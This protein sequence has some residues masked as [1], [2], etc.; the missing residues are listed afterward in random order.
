MRL[1]LLQGG[2]DEGEVAADHL[3]RGAVLESF[4]PMSNTTADGSRRRTSSWRRISTPRVVSPLMPRL[5]TFIARKGGAQTPAPTLRDRVAEEDDG[6]LVLILPARPGRA[7]FAPHL[8]ERVVA[9]DRSCPGQAVVRRGNGKVVADV[10]RDRGRLRLGR[11][12]GRP[13]DEDDRSP[14]SPRG[15]RPGSVPH[16]GEHSRKPGGGTRTHFV[17]G[18]LREWAMSAAARRPRRRLH[19]SSTAASSRVPRLVNV[20][21]HA[22]CSRDDADRLGRD[23]SS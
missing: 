19:S 8:L 9:P 15:T 5:A 7:P 17:G 23:G 13:E 14:A 16:G 1:V 3:G 12:Q 4:V 10:G 21:W 2:D 11:R 22:A 20:T 6:V 18:P